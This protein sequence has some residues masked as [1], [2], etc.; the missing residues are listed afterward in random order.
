MYSNWYSIEQAL[1]TF[2][3]K[4][5]LFYIFQFVLLND[6]R[7]L[8]RIFAPGYKFLNYVTVHKTSRI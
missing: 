4:R 8:G 7:G 5:Y 6:A 1:N 2:Y 3:A